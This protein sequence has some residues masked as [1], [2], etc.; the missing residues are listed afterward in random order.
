MREIE[1]GLTKPKDQGTAR[2]LELAV[3]FLF[4][5]G[6]GS[7]EVDLHKGWSP[8]SPL[9]LLMFRDQLRLNWNHAQF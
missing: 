7:R 2:P 3:S 8:H 1:E 9:P 4:F 6:L 5:W